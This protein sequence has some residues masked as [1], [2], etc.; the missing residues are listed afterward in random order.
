M[1]GRIDAGWNITSPKSLIKRCTKQQYCSASVFV[2][3]YHLHALVLY[4]QSS[5]GLVR[6]SPNMVW[7]Q[8]SGFES[9]T[10]CRYI[11]YAMWPT[12][13]VLIVGR[14]PTYFKVRILSPMLSEF[15]VTLCPRSSQNLY[16]CLLRSGGPSS[17]SDRSH[18][19]SPDRAHKFQSPDVF[20]RYN[21]Q[22][23]SC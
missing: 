6:K 3:I 17:S 5:T 9:G 15:D 20:K 21:L 11:T 8:R 7:I 4:L 13:D 19:I 10:V 14:K 22:Q 12:L 18:P 16:S 23:L 2:A 1:R